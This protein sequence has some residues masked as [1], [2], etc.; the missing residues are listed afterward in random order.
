MAQWTIDRDH[1]ADAGAKPGTNANAVGLVGPSDANLTSEQIANHP[2]S[3][4][5]RMY[6]DDG[7]LYYE[8]FCVLPTGLSAR[9]FAPLEDFGTP[10]AGATRIDYLVEGKGWVTL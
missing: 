1:I 7:A 3:K 10:N 4:A 8:G 9:A 6:D 5:F 2:D